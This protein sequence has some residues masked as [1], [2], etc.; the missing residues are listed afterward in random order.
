M[1][2]IYPAT[3]LTGDG[4]NVPFNVTDQWTLI[5]GDHARETFAVF[6]KMIG[7]NM[8]VKVYVTDH[9]LEIAPSA[10]NKVQLIVDGQPANQLEG[11]VL[12]PDNTT[13][14]VLK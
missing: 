8:A 1:C 4:K 7:D 13:T 14:W 3:V 6:A 5:S 10:D 11:G 2:S 9:Q 12:V